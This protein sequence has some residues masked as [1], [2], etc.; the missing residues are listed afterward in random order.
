MGQKNPLLNLGASS[1]FDQRTSVRQLLSSNFMSDPP[2]P[3]VFASSAFGEPGSHLSQV[4]L[5][6]VLVR[7]RGF[8]LLSVFLRPEPSGF[9]QTGTLLRFSLQSFPHSRS[10][11]P[12]GTFCSLNLSF[13]YFQPQ[14]VHKKTRFSELFSPLS[15]RSWP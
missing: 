4:C 14:L 9:F 3:E 5:T 11:I 1:E 2:S 6:W 15:V 13:L 7:F 10:R 8:S 12:F